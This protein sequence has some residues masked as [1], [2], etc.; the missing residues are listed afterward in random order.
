MTSPV[1]TPELAAGEPRTTS[2][3]STPGSLGS[4]MASSTPSQPRSCAGRGCWIECGLSAP[5]GD[6]ASSSALASDRAGGGALGACTASCAGCDALA[7]VGAAA[8]CTQPESAKHV[9]HATRPLRSRQLNLTAS[10]YHARLARAAWALVVAAL[11]GSV[12]CAETRSGTSG[13]RVRRL[14]ERPRNLARSVST[15]AAHAVGR[16]RRGATLALRKLVSLPPHMVTN[17]EQPVLVHVSDAARASYAGLVTD[18]M[19]PDGSL[20]AEL[21]TGPDGL[22]YAMQKLAGAW[23][24]TQ[25]DARGG[26]LASGSLP[27]CAGCHAQAPCDHVFGLPRPTRSP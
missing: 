18:T 7:E 5:A 19:F 1:T 24:Y 20:L 2:R 6:A 12:A 14:G 27:F 11:C 23:T 9:S 3:T 4:R 26:V 22:G 21:P 8:C 15:R 10:W 17:P 25:L 16:V 13:G